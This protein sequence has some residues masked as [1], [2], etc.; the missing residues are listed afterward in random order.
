MNVYIVHGLDKA[1][2]FLLFSDI[3]LQE[4]LRQFG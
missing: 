3:T 4:F 1:A 2:Y